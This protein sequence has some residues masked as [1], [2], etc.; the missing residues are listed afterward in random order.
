M[1]RKCEVCGE[2]VGPEGRINHWKK[3]HPK[4]FKSYTRLWILSGALI[5]GGAVLLRIIEAASPGS[6]ALSLADWIGYPVLGIGS[7]L[8]FL[9]GRFY[10]GRVRKSLKNN[11]ESSRLSV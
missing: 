9:A 6:E 8:L 11:G 3:Y 10:L 2:N 1:D 7:V 4:Y 5:V